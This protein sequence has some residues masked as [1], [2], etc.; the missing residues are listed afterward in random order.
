MKPTPSPRSRAQRALLAAF[1]LQASLFSVA[2]AADV[3]TLE[4]ESEPPRRWIPW[5][6][7]AVAHVSTSS[8]D[9]EKSTAGLLDDKPKTVSLIPRLEGS[10]TTIEFKEPREIKELALMQGGMKE[11]ALPKDLLLRA[12]GKDVAKVTLENAPEVAQAVPLNRIVGRLEIKVLSVYNDEARKQRWGGFAG[13]A[14]AAFGANEWVLEME[15]LQDHQRELRLTIEAPVATTAK[16][17]GTIGQKS[18][19]MRF[20]LAPLPLKAGKHDYVVSM[21]DLKPAEKFGYDLHA[22]HLERLFVTGPDETVAVRLHAVE[23]TRARVAEE[24]WEALPPLNFPTRE[25]DG[26]TWTE[27]HSYRTAGRFSNST[28]NGLVNEVV[29]GNW[30]RVYTANGDNIHRRQDY[31]F[32]IE[33]FDV[34]DTDSTAE[35]WKVK[36]SAWNPERE[37]VKANWTTMV[38]DRVGENGVTARLT[39]GLL[40]PGFL[41][42]TPKSLTFSSRGG[43]SL[44]VRSGAPDEDEARFLAP[45]KSKS[46]KPMIGPSAILTSEGVLTGP[47]TI[48]KLREPWFVAI[49]GLQDGKPT[50]WGDKA[51]AVLFTSDSAGSIE[52]TATS[53][54]LPEGRWGV[55]TAFHGL[56]NDG[57]EP[58]RVTQRA[59]QLTRMLRTYPVDCREFYLVE[60]D[61]VRIRDEFRYERWG[62]PEWQ[63]P[64]YASIPPLYSWARDSVK[65]TGVP[66]GSASSQEAGIKTPIGPFRWVEGAALEY[67]LPRVNVHHAAWPRREEFADTYKSMGEDIV[68]TINATPGVRPVNRPWILGYHNRWSQGILGGAYHEPEAL[69]ALVDL[70]KQSVERMYAPAS[71]IYRRELFT[72]EPYQSRGW[73]DLSTLP[74]MFGD[75]NSEVGQAAYSTYLYALYSGDWATIRR[76]WP[77]IM[78]TVRGFEIMNDWAIPGTTSREAVKYGS[79]DMDTI[80]YAGVTAMQRMATVLGE[81]TDADRLAYLQTKISAATS[82]RLNFTQ[83]LDPEGKSPRLFGVGF[84]EDGPAI[85]RAAPDSS[86]G[87]DKV[88]MCLT[89][90]GEMPDMYALHLN[91]L[92]K[93]FFT[94]FQKE[95]MDVEFAGWRTMGYNQSRTAAHIANRAWL[96]DWPADGI[97]ADLDIW[98][99]HTKKELTPYVAAGM[100]GAYTAHET[101]VYIVGW[102]P[103]RF[104]SSRYEHAKRVLAVDLDNPAPFE[105]KVHSRT[106]VAELK[107]NGRPLPLTLVRSAGE[108]HTV[109]LSG[110]GQVEIRFADA[111]TR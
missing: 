49:W 73:L 45:E 21:D 12:D 42:D 93:D 96:P 27:G 18:R 66:A 84:A 39:T 4:A 107:L 106:P 8:E 85:E 31:D 99:K 102:E 94:K 46:G 28:Y 29:S 3:P 40:A 87:M 55:A 103:A 59:R 60:K 75:P 34:D 43:G 69:K 37:K 110:G 38:M 108:F 26:K 90:T 57:W 105:L 78:E 47:Q 91:L 72:Q 17:W 101:G 48:S 54:K 63:A 64:D 89:W 35:L 2:H 74:V 36:R 19:F 51:T 71:W 77:R 32:A 44:P 1:C 23:P 20:E 111:P 33:G 6:K 10:T 61:A 109:S 25:I 50:F 58:A 81:K 98:L 68:A 67:S 62:N 104:V 100:F 52:W 56:L 11:W 95:F 83:Y 97:R 70:G 65:W 22:R 76:L 15:P 82:L 7:D 14:E 30:I 88:A 16:V 41:I 92:G 80:S 13:I 79:I 9:Q 24:G 5:P 86:R 53:L